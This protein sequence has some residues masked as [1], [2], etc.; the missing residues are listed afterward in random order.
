MNDITT[1]T[2]PGTTGTT[3]PVS[4]TSIQQPQP[5]HTLPD[6]SPILRIGGELD[7]WICICGNTPLTHGF[8]PCDAQG[9]Y[10]EPT[11]EAWTAN[12]YVCD[13]CGR[14]IEQGTRAVIG[15]RVNNHL[16]PRE[17]QAILAVIEQFGDIRTLLDTAISVD[18]NSQS[19]KQWSIS[20]PSSHAY[21]GRQ[22]APVK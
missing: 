18:E 19:G 14:I 15:Y 1:E 16:T 12:W 17:R 8:Y 5:P 6:P 2:Q 11:P 9:D 10:V 4:D 22:T 13:Q 7:E 3:S 20:T 21:P